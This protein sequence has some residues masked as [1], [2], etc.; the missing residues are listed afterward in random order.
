[1]RFAGKG[2]DRWDR[3]LQLAVKKHICVWSTPALQKR[4]RSF[5]KVSGQP[6]IS[7]H[8]LCCNARWATGSQVV[9][10]VSATQDVRLWKV[11]NF[12]M[13]DQ[14]TMTPSVG[15][16]AQLVRAEDS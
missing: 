13:H 3:W 5:K 14:S 8:L 11:L 6:E 2:E 15:T 12:P 4:K 10:T 1:M 7:A 16:L 9:G